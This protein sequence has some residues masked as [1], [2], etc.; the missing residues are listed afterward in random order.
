MT[1]PLAV[2]W[3]VP[4]NHRNY[5][6]MPASVW[7]RC[8]Q[9]IPYL[10]RLG[11]RSTVNDVRGK[12]DVLV[13]VRMQDE[14]A[15]RLAAEAK[16]RG[17]KVAF[18][19]CVNYF[20]ETGML[21]GGYGVTRTHVDECLRMVSLA[22]VVI[23]GSA[24]IASRAAEFHP[25]VTYLPESVNREHFRYTKAY[26][27]AHGWFAPRPVTAAW[28]GYAVKALELEPFLPLFAARKIPLVII[29]ERRPSLSIP[30]R[31]IRW[32]YASLPRS[33]VRAEFCIA[34]RRLDSPYNLGHS[35]FKIGIFL[36]EGVPALASPVPSYREVLIPERTGLLCDSLRDWEEALDRVRE[37]RDLLRRWSAEARDAMRP[38]L[39]E[40]VARRYA[41][42]FRELVK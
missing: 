9:L 26:D 8:L 40:A 4:V 5:D 2:A 27:D 35:L 22:D 12:A 38:Y 30:F 7:I 16:R 14:S 28:C 41:E 39:T 1:K 29:S 20:D 11:I 21:E 31:Y 25:R 23:A 6:R 18:D 36:A 3:S 32:R 42:L 24:F 17:A 15:S 19:L 34:P 10:E 13:F 33:L 37:D